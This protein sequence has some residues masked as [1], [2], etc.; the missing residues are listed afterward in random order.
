[1][2]SPLFADR[3]LC[4]ILNIVNKIEYKLFKINEEHHFV[5]QSDIVANEGR[6]DDFWFENGFSEDIRIMFFCCCQSCQRDTMWLCVLPQ[7]LKHS[8]VKP[9]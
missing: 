9:F 1:M 2:F 3:F 7:I 6:K 5:T 4:G 8:Q